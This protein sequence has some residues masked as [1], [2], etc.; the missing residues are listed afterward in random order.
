MQLEILYVQ[1]WTP[2]S[3]ASISDF[4]VLQIKE[5][6]HEAI[7]SSILQ[8][9]QI[10]QVSKIWDHQLIRKYFLSCGMF[11]LPRQAPILLVRDSEWSKRQRQGGKGTATGSTEDFEP[12]CV[13]EH[14]S[15]CA[16]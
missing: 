3:Q 8:L 6:P 15:V 9:L 1:T 14:V 12:M 13:S 7:N 16:S 4:V 5:E 11:P 10:K 2:A